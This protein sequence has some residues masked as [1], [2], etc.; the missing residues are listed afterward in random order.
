VGSFLRSQTGARSLTPREGD[1]PDAVLS[2][3]EA[4]LAE[5]RPADTLTELAA[6]PPEGQ[7]AMTEWSSR[8]QLHLAGLDALQALRTAVGGE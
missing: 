8:V 4:I 6:L 1:D 5:G 2:R 3:A 7:A